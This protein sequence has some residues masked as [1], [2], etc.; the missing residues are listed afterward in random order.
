MSN[1][2]DNPMRFIKMSSDTGSLFETEVI[3]KLPTL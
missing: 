2:K 1:T 3:S